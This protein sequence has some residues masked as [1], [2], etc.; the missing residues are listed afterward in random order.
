MKEPKCALWGWIIGEGVLLCCGVCK[1]C[2]TTQESVKDKEHH[3]ILWKL[4]AQALQ[5][6]IEKVSKERI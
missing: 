1:N 2:L 4:A 6:R 5:E 3:E